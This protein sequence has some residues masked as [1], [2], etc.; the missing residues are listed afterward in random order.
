MYPKIMH[1]FGPLYI[2]SYG[3]MI[4][5]AIGIFTWLITKDPRRAKIITTEQFH[6]ILTVGILSA[7]L[8]GRILY[9]VVDGNY[10][11]QDFFSFWQGGFAVLGSLLG[12]LCV[13]PWYLNKHNIPLLPFLDLIALYTPLLQSISRIGCFLAGCCYGKPSSLP[14]A[15][16]YYDEACTAP[17]NLGLHPTQLYSALVLA[18]IFILFKTIFAKLCKKDGQMLSLYIFFMA[19]ERCLTDF[20]RGDQSFSVGIFGSSYQLLACFLMLGAAFSF[21]YVTYRPRTSNVPS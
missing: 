16:T 14:W 19:A 20:F 9:F 5:C 7:L 2:N 1:L 15:V 4:A 11:L 21:C 17:L 3:A 12:V 8:G 10:N 6:W 18:C 13:A